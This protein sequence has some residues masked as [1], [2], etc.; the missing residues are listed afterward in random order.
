M[1][2][3]KSHRQSLNTCE[4]CCCLLGLLLNIG[5]VHAYV[6]HDISSKLL[7][8]YNY[9]IGCI[10]V[11]KPSWDIEQLVMPPKPFLHPQE[12]PAE[13]N[14]STHSSHNSLRAEDW[15]LSF[16]SNLSFYRSVLSI[17]LSI[18]GI[19]LCLYLQ[20]LISQVRDISLNLVIL[21]VKIQWVF[22]QSLS[23]QFF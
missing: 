22:F 1:S 3:N 6:I 19:I 17:R 11:M 7:T 8:S 4:P 16:D 21:L 10:M 13:I 15:M 18:K 2:I 23:E 20:H 12:D 9:A 5:C 14:K